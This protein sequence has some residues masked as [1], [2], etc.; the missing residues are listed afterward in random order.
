[1]NLVVRLVVLLAGSGPVVEISPPESGFGVLERSAGVAERSISLTNRSDRVLRIDL[2]STCE[3][4][5]VNPSSL[6]LPP[7]AVASVQIFFD[8]AD[9]DGPFEKDLIVRTDHP[10]LPKALYRLYGEVRVDPAEPSEA[11]SSSPPSAGH[12]TVTAD[13]YFSPGCRSCRE[14]LERRLPSIE[15]RLGLAVEVR[16]LNVLD[17]EVYSEY[18]SRLEALGVEERV[19]PALVVDEVVLQG[20]R[21]ITDG[22]PELLE[23]AAHKGARLGL[24]SADRSPRKTETGESGAG[25]GASSFEALQSRL[26]VFPVLAAGLL[27]GINPCAFTTLIFL[28]SAL[29]VAGRSRREVLWIGLFF[30]LAVFVTYLAVGFGFF[31]VLR[32]AAVF[33]LIARAIRWALVAA[34]LVFASLSLY[35][36]ISIRAGRTDRV[37]LQLPRA[38]KRRIHRDIK[39]RARS[40]ALITTSLVLGVLVSIFELA[41]TGQVYLPTIVYVLRVKG[42]GAA[43]PYLLLYNL[44][45]VMPLLAV[46]AASY[47]GVSSRAV[48]A[49][50][51]RSAGFVKLSLAALFLGL[52]ALTIL[53]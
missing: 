17:P 8:P 24:D 43:L 32:A 28:L 52:A 26:T 10:D 12:P 9:D 34:L 20:E 2:V 36:Y 30:T 33:P 37:V 29:A 7:G 5:A 44:G 25:E 47:W 21:E 41:C 13:Y 22:L 3:C 1:M 19:Y 31:Q 46:F 6:S 51:Q 18:L 23:R 15:A 53:S 49:F 16:E 14:L 11:P 42:E 27:D 35:D 38:V 39:Q 4:L 48:T 40:A 45:F 50:F